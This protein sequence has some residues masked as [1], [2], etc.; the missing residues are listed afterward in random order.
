MELQANTFGDVFEFPVIGSIVN[1]LNELQNPKR[2]RYCQSTVSELRYKL[3]IINHL[4][5][6]DRRYFLKLIQ[7]DYDEKLE[8][9]ALEPVLLTHIHCFVHSI[10][11]SELRK[12]KVKNVR[13]RYKKKDLKKL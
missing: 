2:V 8:T 13:Q 10:I 9:S 3:R 5:K 7:K 1:I 11:N 12:M 6:T 4:E